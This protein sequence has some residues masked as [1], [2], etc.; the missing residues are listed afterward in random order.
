MSCAS[1]HTGGHTNHRLSDTLGDGQYG[2]PK[3]V[4]S[5]LGVADTKPWAWD[6]QI[7][8]L[9]DQVEKSVRTTLRGRDLEDREV[10]DL[11]AYL[12]TLELPEVSEPGETALIAAGREAFD[13]YTCNRCH[14]APVYTSPGAHNVGL[15]DE[16]GNNRFN[17]PSLRGVKFRRALL[18]DGSAKSLEEVFEVHPGFDVEVQT[19]DLPALIAFLRTL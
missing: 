16:V 10:D 9:E 4:L 19:P 5:L 3:R 8:Q 17:P 11:A 6:G 7:R 15:T 18:H 13:R 14:T 12:R 2:A 1:C